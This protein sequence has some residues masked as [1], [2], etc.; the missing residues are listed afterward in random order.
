MMACVVAV[1]SSSAMYSEEEVQN[2]MY[3]IKQDI[4]TLNRSIGRLQQL[5]A[6]DPHTTRNKAAMVRQLYMHVICV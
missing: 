3:H 2:K 5:V 6:K 1:I 4:T